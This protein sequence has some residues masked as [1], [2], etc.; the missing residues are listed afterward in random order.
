MPSI[1]C[2]WESKHW[3]KSKVGDPQSCPAPTGREGV[4]VPMLSRCGRLFSKLLRPKHLHLHIGFLKFKWTVKTLQLTCAPGP[5]FSLLIFR[6][7][8]LMRRTRASQHEQDGPSCDHT[9]KS[10]IGQTGLRRTG[11]ARQETSQQ[12]L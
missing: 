10:C 4:P 9:R 1:Q 8:D 11:S 6:H 5:N 7:K 12:Q 3:Q 2:S